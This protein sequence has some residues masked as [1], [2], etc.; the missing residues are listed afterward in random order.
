MVDPLFAVLARRKLAADLAN[1][2]RLME[3]GALGD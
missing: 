3:S 1:L 2:K